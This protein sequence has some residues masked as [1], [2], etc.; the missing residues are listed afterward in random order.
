[1]KRLL[2]ALV[3]GGALFAFG[4]ATALAA[5]HHH[6]GHHA[7][8]HS[9]VRFERFGRSTAPAGSS[10][11][12][13]AHNAGM[14]TSFQNGTLTITLNDG[15]TVSGTVTRQTEIECKAPATSSTMQR[16]DHGRDNG[17][18]GDDNGNDNGDDNNNAEHSCSTADLQPAT[19]VREAELKVSGSGATWDKVELVTSQ[20]GDNDNDD[21]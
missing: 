9:R 16:D 17:D 15:S 20:T 2:V 4:P 6:H 3:L 11:Q 14:V 21:S 10:T 19:V 7:R 1:M 5:K 12:S 13:N 8:H 18:R